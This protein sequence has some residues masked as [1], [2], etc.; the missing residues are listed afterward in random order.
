M[1]CHCRAT[2][3]LSSSAARSRSELGY[4]DLVAVESDGRLVIIEI[5]LRRNA[6]A[7][8]AV[9]AQVLTYAAFLKGT[10][11]RELESRILRPHLTQRPFATL[12]EGMRDADQTG[13]FDET[14]LSSRGCGV[15]RGGSLPTRPGPRRGARRTRPADRLSGEH[16]RRG[17]ARP[18]H[19]L[20]LRRRQRADPRP[21]ARRPRARRQSGRRVRGPTAAVTRATAR[22]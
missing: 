21:A 11:P 2:R 12:A 10:E 1:C 3:A 13:T 19:R 14:A 15:A 5:K 8:R 18:H 22:A 4:A 16:Q 20:G 7:R 17:R 9:V 6:E